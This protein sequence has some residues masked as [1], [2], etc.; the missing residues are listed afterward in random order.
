MGR[1]RVECPAL[2]LFQLA[3]CFPAREPFIHHFYWQTKFLLHAAPKTG[4]FFGHFAACAVQPQRQPNDNLAHPM[5]SD[6]FADA[7]HVFI[8]VYA[9]ERGKRLRKPGVGRGDG[10][11]NARA[12]VVKRKNVR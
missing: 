3:F 10:Q 9:F 12:P 7:A 2:L 8:A 4:R 5:I 1:L 6:D 11:A